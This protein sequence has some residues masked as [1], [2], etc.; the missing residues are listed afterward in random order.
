MSDA[1]PNE[2][3]K[4]RFTIVGTNTEVPVDF[5]PVSLELT[6]QNEMQADGDKKVQHV[7]KSSAKLSLEL[8]FD[9]TDTGEDV[10]H[11]THRIEALFKPNT[12][13]TPP[14]VIF[15][16]GAFRFEGLVDSYKQTLDFFSKNGVPLRAVVP[17]SLSQLDYKF[18]QAGS[19]R[20]AKADDTLDLPGGDPSNM[21]AAGGDPDAA[22]GIA[23]ANGL[24]SLRATASA[25][26]S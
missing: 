22:R 4:A 12:D 26:L 2:N 5:N 25:S 24:E 17:L 23:T 18:D 6:V 11:K 3:A 9:S 7:S 14:V 21:A 15:E 16:W 13:K 19:E 1:A 20:T 10:R 8:V